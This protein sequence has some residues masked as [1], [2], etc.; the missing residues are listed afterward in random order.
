MI[1]IH[2]HIYPKG[3]LELLEERDRAPKLERRNDG[4]H[5]FLFENERLITGGTRAINSSYHSIEEKM[6]FMEEHGITHSVLSIGNPWIDFLTSQTAPKWADKLNEELETI[7]EE[8]GQFKALGVLPYQDVDAAVH[9]INSIDKS[10]HLIGASFST[11]P[12]GRHL[13]DPLLNPL[14]ES[15]ETAAVPLFLHPHYIVG[16]DWMHRYG[17]SMVLGLG[18]PFETTT[19]ITRCIL[20]GVL[21][22]F[23]GLQLILAHAGGALPALAG[24]LSVYAEK[25]NRAIRNIRQPFNEYLGMLY[26][27]T[28]TYSAPALRT[29]LEIAGPE[30]LFF[31][32]DHPFGTADPALDK[33]IVEQV[34][35]STEAIEKILF[36]NSLFWLENGTLKS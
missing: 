29:A 32:T 8:H 18:Y 26:F 7:C 28:L 22:R 19:A 23:P 35:S 16:L 3:Y 30:K 9:T 24:R 6:V 2:S 15:A 12:G 13:D 5:L 17:H 31:G 34:G 20:G 25:D 10:T 4:R 14:W 1:D 33:A 21:D 36:H 11:R 27:D